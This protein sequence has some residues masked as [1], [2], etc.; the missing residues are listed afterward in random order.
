M[1]STLV[2]F[3]LARSYRVLGHFAADLDPL[4]LQKILHD[5]FTRVKQ[6]ATSLSLSLSVCLSVRPLLAC[7]VRT[8]VLTDELPQEYLKDLLPETYG[9]TEADL[10]REFFTGPDLP[11]NKPIRT[12]RE[13]VDLL[14]KTYCSRIG[15]QFM[16]LSSPSKKKW[17]QQKV[18]QR[19]Y[20]GINAPK[21]SNNQSH[22]RVIT[23]SI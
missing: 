16:H 23:R 8:T 17:I 18:L 5:P 22:N 21:K 19:R 11:G 1:V 12:L 4:G 14:S 9:F 7:G 3:L 6:V 20:P 10:D 15:V 13:V 2:V